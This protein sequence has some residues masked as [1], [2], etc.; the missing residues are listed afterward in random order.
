[1]S[2]HV[3]KIDHATF[4]EQIAAALA[5]GLSA[6]EQTAFEAHAAECAACSAELKSARE[7]EDRM[8]ALFASAGPIAGMEDRIIQSLRLRGGTT[9]A[10]RQNWR[11]HPAVSKAVT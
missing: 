2:E 4:R 7:A 5:G 10:W 9:F 3:E 6:A 11:I 8:T 1:M